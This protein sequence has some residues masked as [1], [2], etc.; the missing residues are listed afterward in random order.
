MTEPTTPTG[1]RIV[2]DGPWYDSKTARVVILA[3][4]AEAKAQERERLAD[5]I[6]R[7]MMGE[8]MVIVH[9]WMTTGWRETMY[10][11]GV[12]MWSAL[13]AEPQP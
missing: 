13:L 8:G 2:A 9:R 12:A 5:L 1:K 6:T 11:E 3:I 10:D 7:W 4:E